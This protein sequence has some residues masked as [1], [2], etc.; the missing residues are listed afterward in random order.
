MQALTT[1]SYRLLTL[2][3]I[4]ILFTQSAKAE[5]Y[6]YLNEDSVTVL[7]SHV[8]ARYVKN[9]YTILSNDGRILEVVPRALTEEEIRE[10]DR[11]LAV[12]QQEEKEERE[13][14]IADHNLLRIYSTPEDVIRAR[15]T[16]IA[17][18][19]NFI[20]T[21]QG[22]LQRLEIQKRNLASTL[23]DIERAGGAIPKG[24]LNRI[25][26]VDTRIRTTQREIGEKRMEMEALEKSFATDLQRV[27]QLYGSPDS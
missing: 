17:S 8:P 24:P 6:K 27:R 13:Q 22:N 15:D 16:K 20:K 19:D 21:S 11:L 10:R 5:L 7:D 23:A 25:R 12:K 3:L 14:K 26:N 9:G 1:V 4:Q 2:F 18:V